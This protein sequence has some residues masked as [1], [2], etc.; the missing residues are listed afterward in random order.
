MAVPFF[1]TMG[2]VMGSGGIS[3]K[4]IARADACVGWIARRHGD[5]QHR[6]FVFLRRQFRI[7]RGRYGLP[8][9]H[10]HPDDGGAGLRRRLLTAVTITSSCEG[11]LVPP[12]HNMVINATTAG[13][14][15]V[16]ALFLA[17]VTAG[18][19]AGARA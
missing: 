14:L 16:G 11:L 18:R 17:G 9:H 10:P 8:G 3:Q 5:V 15:S 6:R 2:R 4:L 19:T 12:S 7:R 1:I 13:G